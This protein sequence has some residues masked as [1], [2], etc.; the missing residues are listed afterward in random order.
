MHKFERELNEQILLAVSSKLLEFLAE[1]NRNDEIKS[2]CIDLL[3]LDE[4]LEKSSEPQSEKLKG[5]EDN[6]NAIKEKLNNYKEEKTPR[7]YSNL[8]Y[9][10]LLWRA[11]ERKNNDDLTEE[12]FLSYSALKNVEDNSQ[13]INLPVISE[14]YASFLCY[15]QYLKTASYKEARGAEAAG[16]SGAGYEKQSY[17][18]KQRENAGN[19]KTGGTIKSIQQ[20]VD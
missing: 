3:Y 4:D 11:P 1:E 18:D 15:R 8:Q 2:V 6:L 5:L 16:V 17:L 10:H 12:S 9:T 13:E 20:N 7:F 19:N 14:K